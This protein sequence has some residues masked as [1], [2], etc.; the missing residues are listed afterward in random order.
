M[1]FNRWFC[2]ALLA[3]GGCAP[4]S[5]VRILVPTAP[6]AQSLINDSR[7]AESVSPS[8]EYSVKVIPS[9]PRH[10][11]PGTYRVSASGS[12]LWEKEFP[13]SFE[14]VWI[15]DDGAFAGYGYTA[16]YEGFGGGRDSYGDLV[17]A[18]IDRRGDVLAEKRFKRE[19][20]GYFH[21]PPY[22]IV[23]NTCA[24]EH[25][26]SVVLDVQGIA[27]EE[28]V[29]GIWLLDLDAIAVTKVELPYTK[30]SFAQAGWLLQ[31][32]AIPGT[33]LMIGQWYENLSSNKLGPSFVVLD[34]RLASVWKEN[35]PSDF[36]NPSDSDDVQDVI[37]R[38]RSSGSIVATGHESF[39]LR[40]V[41]PPELV[42]YEV[43]NGVV[44]ERRRR[45]F[46]ESLVPK[47][48]TTYIDWSGSPVKSLA[49]EAVLDLAPSDSLVAGGVELMPG[50]NGSLALLKYEEGSVYVL[51]VDK[52]GS[53]VSRTRIDGSWKEG[54]IFASCHLGGSRYAVALTNYEN[55]TATLVLVDA[56]SQTQ[57]AIT[58]MPGKYIDS[59]AF[60]HGLVAILGRIPSRYS[61]A[62]FL[63]VVDLQGEK[64]WEKVQNGYRNE[65]G[66]L[67]APEDVAMRGGEIFVLN[68]ISHKVNVYET[69]SGKF[70]RGY[71]LELLWGVEPAYVTELNL[72]EGGFVLDGY[73]YDKEL[74][75]TGLDFKR[76]VAFTPKFPDG[77]LVDVWLGP[78][79]GENGSLWVIGTDAIHRLDSK[80][81]IV[82]SLGRQRSETGLS[83]VY[84]A[85]TNSR[86]RIFVSDGPTGSVFAYD[87]A[88]RMVT[89]CKPS[90]GDFRDYPANAM[91]E[92]SN[93]GHVF[94]R[95]FDLDAFIEYSPEGRRLGVRPSQPIDD[96]EEPHHF[97]AKARGENTRWHGTLLVDGE[98]NV[99]A[100]IG[101]RHDE[102]WLGGALLEAPDGT[103]VTLD[104]D[105]DTWICSYHSPEGKSHAMMT[106]GLPRDDYFGAVYDGE[107][108][109]IALE[110]GI[111]AVDRTGKPAWHAMW[112]NGE[113]PTEMLGILGP[114]RVAVRTKAGLQVLRV[115]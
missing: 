111:V 17:L 54:G 18:I 73:S 63:T 6:H 107:L 109:L 80:G 50:P 5:P 100:N 58:E 42:E 70:L 10:G 74:V 66:E 95:S 36:S 11:G 88:F 104:L 97:L 51:L 85:K 1:T 96:F 28:G 114:G 61:Q 59:V 69:A 110:K 78:L 108:V 2:L 52:A 77:K 47:R 105:E 40:R 87:K 3:L 39:M 41:V 93:A 75:V 83:E 33:S 65:P 38:L 91:F 13:Y 14:E 98:N 57:K 16:G 115:E 23:G 4:V 64:K 92:V 102:A 37:D 99:V 72:V 27:S 8:K 35:W 53:I 20:S 55:D 30:P 46:E 113:P 82:Q 103:F 43:K 26:R 15:N 79:E 21:A 29:E 49:I 90:P 67:F 89:E 76:K 84:D 45:P 81:E 101:R 106:F 56:Q 34:D 19:A 71:D 22:P 48:Q 68:N 24:F 12:V 62:D 60:E 9:T 112:P 7:L 44:R 31:L 25:H 94:V 86:D 32:E